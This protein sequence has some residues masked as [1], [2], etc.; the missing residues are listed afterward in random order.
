MG[1]RASASWDPTLGLCKRVQNE[2]DWYVNRWV[3][4]VVDQL[5][6]TWTSLVWGSRIEEILRRAPPLL[7][8]VVGPSYTSA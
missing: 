8:Q 3:A 5:E 2:D 6:T 1:N 7:N 4:A